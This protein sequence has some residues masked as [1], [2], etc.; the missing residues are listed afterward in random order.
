MQMSHSRNNEK[1]EIYNSPLQRI[2]INLKLLL[3]Q[4]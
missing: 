2:A 4:R 3:A 1:R